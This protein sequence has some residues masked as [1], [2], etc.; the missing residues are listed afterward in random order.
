MQNAEPDQRS[1]NDTVNTI[2]EILRNARPDLRQIN[3][4]V[5]IMP[6]K[7]CDLQ[8]LINMINNNIH[9]ATHGKDISK[10]HYQFL[11]CGGTAGIG[12]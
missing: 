6:L 1:L 4:T 11:V 8:K 5:N 12:K 10:E 3:D 7:D 9:N 2:T